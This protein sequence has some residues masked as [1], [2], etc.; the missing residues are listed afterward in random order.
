MPHGLAEVLTIMLNFRAF[1]LTITILIG[2]SNALT[3][4]TQKVGNSRLNLYNE[5]CSM[6]Y[7]GWDRNLSISYLN[8]PSLADG[9]DISFSGM[10]IKRGNLFGGGNIIDAYSPYSR[11]R[12]SFHHHNEAGVDSLGIVS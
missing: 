7:N 4:R 9:A 3:L 8:Y 1:L 11:N 2:L 12:G 6:K 5:S 10:R